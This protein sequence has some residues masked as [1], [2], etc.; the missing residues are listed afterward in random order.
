VTSA[1]LSVAEGW[2]VASGKGQGASD[3]GQ[4]VCLSKK[5]VTALDLVVW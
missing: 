4:V 3:K 5:D 2:Q 1:A